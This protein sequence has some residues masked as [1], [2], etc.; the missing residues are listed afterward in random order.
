MNKRNHL[1]NLKIFGPVCCMGLMFVF[2]S[3]SSSLLDKEIVISND[4]NIDRK[5]ETVTIPYEAIS[6][7]VENKDIMNVCIKDVQTEKYLQTQALDYDGDGTYEELIFQIDIGAKSRKKY[8]VEKCN[9]KEH[10]YNTTK[11]TYA[12]FAPERIDDLAWEN[13]RVAFRIYGPT[14]Q[15]L[16]E[17]GKEGGTL[18]SGIDCWLKKV[19][20]SIIDKWYAN[21]TREPG[22]YHIDHG[23]GYDPYHVGSSRGCGGIGLWENNKLYTSKNF[24]KYKII[25]NGPIR[26]VIEAEYK[27]YGNGTKTVSEKKRITIDLGSNLS[28]YEVS[29]SS[30]SDINNYAI[31]LTLHDKTGIVSNN[32]SEGWFSYWEKIDNS[33]LGTAIVTNSKCVNEY[34][35]FRV[36]E[37]EKSHL[38]VF[39]HPENNKLI[40]YS[41][42]GW[43]ESHQFNSLE[44]WN[45]YLSNYVK[46]LNS[47]LKIRY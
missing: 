7:L 27:P 9:H 36:N 23:E 18:S 17:S 2:N 28:K 43:K 45:K 11:R 47:P 6:T 40:Y 19:N 38:F 42:F 22:Y 39:V 16:T 21:N 20:Y 37:E 31:G 33:E 24:F 15:K 41:G 4:L 3:C 46:R 1:R 10:L 5:S 35:D 8:K 30:N 13:D 29:L 26:T 14:A 34:N 12:R 25:A 44:E 32:P